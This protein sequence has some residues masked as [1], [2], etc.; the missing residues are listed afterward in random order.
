M[1]TFDRLE[2]LAQRLVEGSFN[3]LFKPEAGQQT[4]S[5]AL[6]GAET[7]ALPDETVEVQ[8]SGSTQAAARWFLV[9]GER[10]LRLGEPVISLGRALDNDVILNDPTVSRYH[11]QLRWRDNHYYLCP[12]AGKPVTE[13]KAQTA[14]QRLNG[15]KPL[16]T[17]NHQPVVDQP[18]VSG[19]V[20]Q[21]GR[22]VL[23]VIVVAE[24]A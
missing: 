18:L 20:I 17:V 14:T 19:D 4:A 9:V 21:L 16:L 7:P 24:N 13:D 6:D 15:A 3:R 2:T 23:T 1:N 22:T 5:Q 12:P 8:L 10:R 11:A